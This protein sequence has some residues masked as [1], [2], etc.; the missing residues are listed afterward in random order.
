MMVSN[1]KHVSFVLY[2]LLNSALAQAQSMR[3]EDLK[4]QSL[5]FENLKSLDLMLNRDF[6]FDKYP[7]MGLKL[8]KGVRLTHKKIENP[9]QPFCYLNGDQSPFT[10]DYKNMS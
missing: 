3:M 7:N 6:T 4:I 10:A 8:Q 1:F 2:F 9:A 5:K